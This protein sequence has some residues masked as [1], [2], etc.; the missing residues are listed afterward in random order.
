MTLS[1][2]P[3]IAARLLLPWVCVLRDTHPELD[4]HI[5][6]S[7]EAVALDGVTADFAIRYGSDW[8]GCRAWT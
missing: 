6:A 4:L 8:P 2:T 5:H 3:A 1:A 7:H